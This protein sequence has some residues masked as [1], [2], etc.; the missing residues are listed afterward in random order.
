MPR[1][2][3]RDRIPF[4]CRNCVTRA[5]ARPSSQLICGQC[6]LALDPKFPTHYPQEADPPKPNR[7]QVDPRDIAFTDLALPPLIRERWEQLQATNPDPD[8]AVVRQTK[9]AKPANA[10]GVRDRQLHMAV[11]HLISW[12]DQHDADLA[13]L[14]PR[15]RIHRYLD[16]LAAENIR[17]Y[18]A[19]GWNGAV[20]PVFGVTCEAVR[21]VKNV[22]LADHGDQGVAS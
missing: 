8:P 3:K 4:T 19:P 12:S 18:L 6:H 10:H 5:Y 15:A 20:A 17:S 14:R 16:H 9:D 13:D 7:P 21:Q 1:R 22:W 11:E 2:I